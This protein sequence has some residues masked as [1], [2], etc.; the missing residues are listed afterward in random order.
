[1]YRCCCRWETLSAADKLEMRNFLL[2]FLVEKH[3]SLV[4]FVLKKT[5]KAVVD[6]GKRQWPDEYADFLRATLEFTAR[7]DTCSV[8]LSMLLMIMEVRVGGTCV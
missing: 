4:P 2:S 5:Q 6:I 1:M 3:K 8:G 7:P